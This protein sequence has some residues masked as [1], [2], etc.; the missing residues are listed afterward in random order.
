MSILLTDDDEIH[1]LN[2]RWLARDYPTDVMAFSQIEGEP[3]PGNFLGDV[4]VSV[5]TAERQAKELGH[6][7]ERELDRLLVHGVL[8][9]LGRE[10]AKGGWNAR[11][12][13][14]EEE[15]IMGILD[16]EAGN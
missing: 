10:H 5:E 15:R 3:F 9:L 8:H 14:R 4:V 2:S 12:M 7:L 11:K 1:D 16:G 6:G 13:R